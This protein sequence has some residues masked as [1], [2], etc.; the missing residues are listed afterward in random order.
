MSW[1]VI[2]PYLKP[3]EPLILDDTISDILVNGSAAVFIER[4]GQMQ[5]VPG[6]VVP[7]RS[8]QVAVRNIARVLGDEISEE[9]PLLDARLPDGSRVAAVFPPCSVTGTTLAIR[10]FHSKLYT[11]EELVHTGTLPKEVLHILRQSIERRENILISGGTGTGKTTMLNALGAFLPSEDRVVVIEDTSEI[12]LTQKNLVR[13]EA[14]RQQSN[15]PAVTIRDLLRATLRL[16]P[17]RIVV[18]E[19]R[20]EEAMDLLQALNT[21]HAGTLCTIHANSAAKT[22]SRFATC[23]QL[24]GVDLPYK[25]VRANIA[26]ALNVVLHIERHHGKR[27]VTEVLRVKAYDQERDCYEFEMLFGKGS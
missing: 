3:I 2:L 14:R 22:L 13:L 15:L 24:S 4:H 11:A 17:D 27:F 1:H 5:A 16:R 7:E 19:V 12:Q 10:K 20:G 9:K 18:G 26:E 21:G 23:V 8:L 6:V 25:A